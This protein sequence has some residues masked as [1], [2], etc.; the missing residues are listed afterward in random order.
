MSNTLYSFVDFDRSRKARWMLE[1]L[2]LSFRDIKIVLIPV[3][4]DENNG[5]RD[6]KSIYI[7]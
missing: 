4:F 1:E 7:A 3:D 5:L 6:L 2:E